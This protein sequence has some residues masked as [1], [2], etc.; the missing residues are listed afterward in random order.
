MAAPDELV[1]QELQVS[2][3]SSHPEVLAVVDA[4]L[5]AEVPW[6]TRLAALTAVVWRALGSPSG[7]GLYASSPPGKRLVLA[8]SQGA[9]AAMWFGWGKDIPG[10][11]AEE[12]AVQFVPNVR[13]FPGHRM[14]DRSVVASVAVPITVQGVVLAVIEARQ[15]ATEEFGLVQAEL[16]QA[17]AAR[18]ADHWPRAWTGGVATDR[19][20]KMGEGQS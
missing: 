10:R 18:L 15:A 20:P 3:A 9:P 6:I 8:A 19:A 1:G 5:G 11:A 14:T 13:A 17:V 4:I 16:L 2:A 12:R 7:V